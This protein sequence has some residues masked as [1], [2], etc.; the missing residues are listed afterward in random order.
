MALCS[1]LGIE[2]VVAQ[3]DVPE[4]AQLAKRFT[5]NLSKG[6]TMDRKFCDQREPDPDQESAWRFCRAYFEGVI[7]SIFGVVCRINFENR[8]R[9]HYEQ[10]CPWEGKEDPAWYALRN[11]VFATGSRQVLS[12]ENKPRTFAEAST[13]SWKYFQNALSVYTELLLV[14]TGLMAVQA[15]IVLVRFVLSELSDM[16]R[17]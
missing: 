9:T 1:S 11:A 6:L 10:G 4:F 17:S 12:T 14:K 8:L 2:W 5:S 7:D 15:L 13:Q 3:T 16:S